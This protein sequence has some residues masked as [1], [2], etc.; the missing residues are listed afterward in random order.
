MRSIVWLDRERAGLPEIGPEI[1]GVQT[2]NGR[3]VEVRPVLGLRSA[4]DAIATLAPG[5]YSDPGLAA[6]VLCLRREM[7]RLEATFSRFALA[8]HR[9]GGVCW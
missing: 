4:V 5:E 9:R 8:A 7:D 3:Q 1:G 6:E 2:M